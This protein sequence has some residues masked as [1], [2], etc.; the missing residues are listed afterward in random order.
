[1]TSNFIYVTLQLVTRS[2]Q[3][4]NDNSNVLENL[5]DRLCARILDS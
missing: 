1:V 4:T 5:P 2:D 3:V